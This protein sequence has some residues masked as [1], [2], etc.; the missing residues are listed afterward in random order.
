ML[1]IYNMSSVAIS[2]FEV[3]MSDTLN[4]KSIPSPVSFT[5]APN[6]SNTHPVIFQ[7]TQLNRPQKL[8]GLIRYSVSIITM[9]FFFFSLKIKI[10]NLRILT[11]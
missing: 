2:S 9:R 8:N 7:F 4:M 10:D 5:L 11:K 1:T 6:Q 3:S